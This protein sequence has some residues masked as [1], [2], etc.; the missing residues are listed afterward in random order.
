MKFVADEHFPAAAV[1]VLVEAGFEVLEVSKNYSASADPEILGLCMV[2]GRTLLTMDKD[3][4]ALAFLDRLPATCGVILFRLNR[5]K[6]D[7][8]CQIVLQAVRSESYGT[9]Y[10]TVVTKN[11]IRRRALHER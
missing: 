10:F 7:E 3:F 8:F 5:V 9:G 1:R 2:E 4:G 6:R 11:K